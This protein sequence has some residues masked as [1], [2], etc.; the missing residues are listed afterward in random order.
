MKLENLC[1]SGAA[2]YGATFSK[3]LALSL[4]IPVQRYI[5][6]VKTC[7]ELKISSSE[8]RTLFD[9]ARLKRME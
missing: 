2:I 5:D 6:S 8:P 9:F 4:L 1:M 7:I 3:K